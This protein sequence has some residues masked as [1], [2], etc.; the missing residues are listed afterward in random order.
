MNYKVESVEQEKSALENKI[1]KNKLAI[2]IL[3]QADRLLSKLHR[4]FPDKTAMISFMSKDGQGISGPLIHRISCDHE[5]LGD[6]PR[7]MLDRE[8][9]QK[10]CLED[11]KKY[12]TEIL[13]TDCSYCEYCSPRL[14]Q[15]DIENDR[16]SIRKEL[17]ELRKKLKEVNLKIKLEEKKELRRKK[18]LEKKRRIEE[19]R[20]NKRFRLSKSLQRACDKYKALYFGKIKSFDHRL[21]PSFIAIRLE[22]RKILLATG[23]GGFRGE[24]YV[25]EYS[26]VQYINN[27]GRELSPDELTVDEKQLIENG[28]SHGPHSGNPYSE[29]HF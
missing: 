23:Y 24:D 17:Y 10:D 3:S 7:H 18:E 5:R 4:E 28:F 8:E 29:V 27:Y 2:E 26:N 11:A 25:I 13:N 1:T 22:K 16:Q 14:N 19:K 12:I 20:I 6:L 21:K 15:R 9:I